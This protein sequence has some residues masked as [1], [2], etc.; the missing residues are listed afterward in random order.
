[1]KF[2][3][4]TAFLFIVL[5]NYLA[6]EDSNNLPKIY[7][8]TYPEVN[9]EAKIKILEDAAEADLENAGPLYIL[10]IKE[11]LANSL[12]LNSQPQY[13]TIAVLAVKQI[14]ETGYTGQKRLLWDLY[15]H[16]SQS[17]TRVVVLE[18]FGRI[19]EGDSYIIK[20][21]NELL[22]NTNTLVRSGLKTDLIVVFSLIQTIGLIGDDSSFPILF[23]ARSLQGYPIRLRDLAEKS[24]LSIGGD[25]E[26]NLLGII[27]N[28]YAFG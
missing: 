22:K 2:F 23:E 10:A 11:V 27:R 9:L 24:L 20:N 6:A 14:A 8:D 25:L 18:A 28:R 13:R 15:R 7:M 12:T 4:R 5:V 3:M 21:L 19:A 17:I 16:D 26:A 1:M